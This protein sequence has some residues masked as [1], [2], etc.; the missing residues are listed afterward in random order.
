MLLLLT[1]TVFIVLYTIF[2]H[3]RSILFIFLQGIA[4]LDSLSKLYDRPAF[5]TTFVEGECTHWLK[6]LLDLVDI[7]KDHPEVVF[8]EFLRQTD[9]LEQHHDLIVKHVR[10]CIEGACMSV[11]L[12]NY[13]SSLLQNCIMTN[14][15]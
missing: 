14:G 15:S 4:F 13:L 7:T 8:K 5:D 1:I 9:V 10:N 11:S 3:K 6:L 2:S 12:T